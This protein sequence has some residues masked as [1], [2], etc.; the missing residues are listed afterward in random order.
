MLNLLILRLVAILATGGQEGSPRAETVTSPRVAQVRLAETLAEADAIQSIRIARNKIAF[1]VTRGDQ[2][3]EVVATTRAKGQ[4]VGLAITPTP[5]VHESSF[6]DLSWLSE[7]LATVTAIV[8]LV[9]D[10]DDAIT[11]VTNDGRRYIVIPGRGSGG[12]VAVEAR[13]AGEWNR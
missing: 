6:G 8:Q 12:N 4:V 1:A 13:W 10:E 5:R 11:F 9:P 7:E 2:S 3:F